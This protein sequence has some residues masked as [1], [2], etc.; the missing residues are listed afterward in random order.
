MCMELM[1]YIEQHPLNV[2]ITFDDP[3]DSIPEI[4]ILNNI[5]NNSKGITEN[6][7]LIKYKNTSELNNI[8]S[9]NPDFQYVEP[10]SD[11]DSDSE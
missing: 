10:E 11:S 5:Y 8:I 3:P 9:S 1:N 7:K 6:I 4:I 2:A